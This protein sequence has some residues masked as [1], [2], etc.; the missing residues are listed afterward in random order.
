LFLA[1]DVHQGS[2]SSLPVLLMLHVCAS[3]QELI[4]CYAF[5]ASGTEFVCVCTSGAS[6]VELLIILDVD[7]MGCNQNGMPVGSHRGP[8]ARKCHMNV[9]IIDV[10]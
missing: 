6:S 3:G 9:R 1:L 7:D 10:L 5:G 2:K 8:E 4:I